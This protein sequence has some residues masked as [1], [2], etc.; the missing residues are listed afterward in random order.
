MLLVDYCLLVDNFLMFFR[1]V[2]WSFVVCS[3]LLVVG[4]CGCCVVLL[5]VR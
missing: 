3:M 2:V 5:V 1:C 4:V